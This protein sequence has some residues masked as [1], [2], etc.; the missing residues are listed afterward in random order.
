MATKNAGA[1]RGFV[2]PQR[3]DETDEEY[4][5]PS[6]RAEMEKEKAEAEEKAKT[7]AAY[8]AASKNMKHG[9]KVKKYAKGGHVSSASSRADGIA[10]KGHTRGKYL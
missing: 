2:N 5:T 1:G 4:V 8:D 9:G 10:Q 3:T 7:D 6:Q